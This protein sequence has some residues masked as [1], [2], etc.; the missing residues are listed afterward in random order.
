M[1]RLFAAILILCAAFGAF[2]LFTLKSQFSV[3]LDREGEK[4][5]IEFKINESGSYVLAVEFN[6][7]KKED[8]QKIAFAPMSLSL[9]FAQKD[10]GAALFDDNINIRGISLEGKDGKVYREIERFYLN[11]G[12]YEVE[13]VVDKDMGILREYKPRFKIMRAKNGG[14]K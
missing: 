1:R 8:M 2:L 14:S 3:E 5:A 13:V 10:G 6:D 4:S 7:V 9:R 11:E 12:R